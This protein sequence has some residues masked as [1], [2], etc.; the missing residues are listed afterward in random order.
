MQLS[1][2]HKALLALR[3]FV[4]SLRRDEVSLFHQ[5][6][7]RYQ[8]PAES[9]EEAV[10]GEFHESAVCLR[11][12]GGADIAEIARAVEQIETSWPA[13]SRETQGRL[14]SEIETA[15][16]YREAGGSAAVALWSRILKLAER[17]TENCVPLEGLSAAL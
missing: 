6:A 1:D 7:A 8:G 11:H 14:V 15:I 16:A 13:L 5:I 4:R 12:L 9:F 17:T 3:P 10:L 2:K